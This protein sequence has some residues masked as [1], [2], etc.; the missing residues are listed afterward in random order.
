MLLPHESAV[1]ASSGWL[2]DKRVQADSPL[3]LSLALLVSLASAR[4]ERPTVNYHALDASG[5]FDQLR[6]G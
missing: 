4:A 3:S 5:S 1:N 6:E 2:P